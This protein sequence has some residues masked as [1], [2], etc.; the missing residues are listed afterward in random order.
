MPLPPTS[1]PALSRE[2]VARVEVGH[3]EVSPAVARMLVVCFLALIV[4]VSAVE[5]W[6]MA[7]R[8]EPTAWA[9]LRALPGTVAPAVGDG[10]PTRR[11]LGANRAVLAG[12]QTFEDQLEQESALGS[13]LR[14]PAQRLL[15]RWL[16][17]GNER[18]YVGRD[19]QLFFRPDVE[20]VTGAPFLDPQQQGRRV[21]AAAEWE[22]PPAVDPRPALR[23]L[24]LD[25]DRRGITL[26]V[27]PTP[28]K[29]TV[30]PEGLSAAYAGFPAPVQNP[31]FDA[32][33]GDLRREGLL[34]YD[35]APMLVEMRL[36][37]HEAPYLRTDTHWRPH[38]MQ[39]VAAD[40]ARMLAR[41]AGLRRGDRV[42]GLEAR[43]VRQAGDTARM[44]DLPPD[45][46]DYPAEEVEVQ[47]VTTA[48]GSP[49]RPTPGAEVLLLGDSFS[50]IYALDSMGWGTAAGLGEHLSA[51]LG[52]PVDRLVQNDAGAVATRAMLQ[53]IS[54][55]DP[56][57]LARTRVVIY[58]F[59]T[60]ELAQGDWQVLPLAPP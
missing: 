27:V 50:N 35:P 49:W 47:R 51:A 6:R 32:L 44:L 37:T 42:Y 55:T 15:S 43:R 40:L 5:L 11:V 13:A 20:Y 16:G 39:A 3:T 18:V 26:L 23:Q 17:A 54:E 8:H 41:D 29:P 12:L 53:R 60:R 34:V 10:T 1:R 57:R 2:D 28:V 48:D 21:T 59:A 24:K 22:R 33:V 30:H 7:T 38:A 56:D 52:R 58:Q 46:I 4:G 25:L 14:P 19:G 45:Q 36:R 31:S 9:H